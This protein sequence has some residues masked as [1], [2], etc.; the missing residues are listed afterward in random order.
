MHLLLQLAV[1]LFSVPYWSVHG[2]YAF[3]AIKRAMPWAIVLT[4]FATDRSMHIDVAVFDGDT[5]YNFIG[6]VPPRTMPSRTTVYIKQAPATG[7]RLASFTQQRK[8]HW[9]MDIF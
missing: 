3:M 2:E 7:H 8:S 4:Y 6:G 9:R 5:S 1:I